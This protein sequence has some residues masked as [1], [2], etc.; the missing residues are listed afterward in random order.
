MTDKKT[1]VFCS[2]GKDVRAYTDQLRVQQDIIKNSAGEWELLSH[3]A[4][5]QAAMDDKSFSS[6]VSRYLQ[7][8]NGLDGKEHSVY[9]ALIDSYL[10]EQ[11]LTPYIPVFEKVAKQLVQ[12][13]KTQPRLDAVNE[14]GAL[15]SVRA[16]CQWLGWPESVEPR[17]LQWMR[18]NHA[19]TRSKD[20]QL[21]SKVAKQ[22]DGIIREMVQ[23]RRRLAAKSSDDVTSQLCHERVNG[24][25]LTDGELVSILRNWTGGDLGSIALCV[26]VLLHKLATQPEL[27]ETLDYYTD[28]ELEAFIEEV[29]RIDD[30]FVSNRRITTCPVHIA[31][32]EIPAGEK[33]RLNWT[34]ANRDEA[35]FYDNQFDCHENQENNLVFGIG[36]HACPGRLLSLWEL[37]ILLRALLA[38]LESISLDP[39]Q[40]VQREVY[41]LGGY[42]CIP[43]IL[44]FK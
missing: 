13:L 14:L 33:I 28:E 41:P 36:K 34:S 22:F 9:R 24:R 18:D 42:H 1:A 3:Q 6:A 5:V 21:M 20:P 43:I 17:L 12:E 10:N 19:A 37:R 8:P 15:F 29:L 40:P 7:I 31:G 44:T 25:L 30:P 35:V 26:G 32:Q 11:A 27:L 39:E 2:E 23:P 38:E 4:V 16:Q